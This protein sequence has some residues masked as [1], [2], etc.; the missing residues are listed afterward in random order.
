MDVGELIELLGPTVRL[1]TP[2]HT[3]ERSIRWAHVTDL[4]DPS[5]YLRGGELVLTNGLWYR[6]V[7]DADRFAAAVAEAGAPVIGLA[8]YDEQ[9]VPE[10][11]VDACE[12]R[13]LLLLLLPDIP[14]RD[15]AEAVTTRIV[16]ERRG[17]RL[18]GTSDAAE[19]ARRLADG[20]GPEALTDLLSAMAGTTCWILFRDGSTVG[21]APSDADDVS[22]VWRLA[23][24]MSMPPGSVTE[25]A[26]SRQRRATAGPIGFS[27]SPRG[28]EQ[29]A[30]VL[31]CDGSL[32]AM[33]DRV[34]TLFWLATNYLPST[35][36]GLPAAEREHAF[37]ALLHGMADG[38]VGDAEARDRAA[39]IAPA[40]RPEPGRSIAAI[41]AEDPA[42]LDPA[43]L[44]GAVRTIPGLRDSGVLAAFAAD[45]GPGR[46][47]IVGTRAVA[48]FRTDAAELDVLAEAVWSRLMQIRAATTLGAAA[49]GSASP[50]LGRLVGQATNALRVASRASSPRRWAT[51]RDAGSH[52][53]L[54]SAADPS[55]LE[56]LHFTTLAPLLGYDA[57]H[58]ARLV[59]T[60]VV[61]LE[62]GGSWQRTA[63]CLHL[64]VNSLRYRIG[65][66]ESLTMRSLANTADRVDFFLA[67]RAW[68]ESERSVR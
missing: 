43:L 53:L 38:S 66:I 64:H 30:A 9:D 55:V 67:L 54:L 16:E 6:E 52:L 18:R 12:E 63:E 8:L 15:V 50:G 3:S 39:A 31:V 42:G 33:G 35:G 2:L 47:G 25:L 14:F 40:I 36:A 10:G 37:S 11:L 26:L 20:A 44:D 24:S 65:R 61:F 41:V 68:E 19:L 22:A 34:D 21:P 48:L 49:D 46:P 57:Q 62:H 59:E 58:D 13:G 60:L 7:G 4:A 32:G 28:V 45:A 29:I 5:S 1:A 51:A 23:F 17:A 56:S 27:P